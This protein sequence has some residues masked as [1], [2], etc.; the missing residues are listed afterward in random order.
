MPGPKGAHRVHQLEGGAN[1]PLGIVLVRRG[2]TPDRHDCI[3]DELL[4]R[5]A[6]ATDDIAPEVEVTR[7]ELTGVL[8]I[9]PLGERR[10]A[11][12]VREEDRDQA[13]FRDG[14]LTGLRATGSGFGR[15]A[16]GRNGQRGRA[17][18]AELGRGRVRRAAVRAARGQARAAFRA[19]LAAC[20][21]LGAAGHTDHPDRS[22]IE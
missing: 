4:D 5:P 8:G 1:C 19:E 20:F 17:L 2:R 9:A 6:V 7:Q 3:A 18:A 10:E 11:H 14:A 15:G 21:V 12:Q 22:I 13:A 16:C